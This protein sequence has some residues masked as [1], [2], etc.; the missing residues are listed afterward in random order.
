[1][2]VNGTEECAAGVKVELKKEGVLVAEQKSDD[3]G[4]FKFDNLLEN[5]GEYELIIFKNEHETRRIQVEVAGSK[6][7]G[8]VNLDE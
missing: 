7:I 1:M 2:Q 6:A 5:S 4:D 3:F 8:T